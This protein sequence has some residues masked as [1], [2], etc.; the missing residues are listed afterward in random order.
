MDGE[1]GRRSTA[2]ERR[3]EI[4]L[5]C[6]SDLQLADSLTIQII[7]ILKR[8]CS[9]KGSHVVCEIYQFAPKIVKYNRYS[10]SKVTTEET[11]CI[12]RG[13]LHLVNCNQVLDFTC[14]RAALANNLT[15]P[16]G[17]GHNNTTKNAL[18]HSVS[19]EAE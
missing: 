7:E 9:T 2:D 13:T 19:D 3:R 12:V 4:F 15:V 5:T 17:Q 1:K 16:I 11:F 14:G 8:N 6:R 10:T 18:S